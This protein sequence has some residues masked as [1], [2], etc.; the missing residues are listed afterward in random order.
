MIHL[1]DIGYHLAAIT[2]YVIFL[3]YIGRHGE[4]AGGGGESG[5]H[6]HNN[7]DIIL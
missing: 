4:E 5:H 6:C 7:I 2:N 3:Y 1:G